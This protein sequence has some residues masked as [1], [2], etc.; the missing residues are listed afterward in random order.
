MA[1]DAYYEYVTFLIRMHRI[2]EER[3]KLPKKSRKQISDDIEFCLH[4]KL[5][6][7]IQSCYADVK[8]KLN[9]KKYICKKLEKIGGLDAHEKLTWDIN[10]QHKEIERNSIRF[11]GMH[12]D[13]CICLVCCILHANLGFFSIDCDS[14]NHNDTDKNLIERINSVGSCGTSC[15][16]CGGHR[17]SMTEEEQDKWDNICGDRWCKCPS[18]WKEVILC[19]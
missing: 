12:D 10:H 2:A 5:T 13:R 11:G 8:K 3:K 14:D 17:C 7:L 16:D 15:S 6:C 1:T 4:E 9:I 19:V 18:N